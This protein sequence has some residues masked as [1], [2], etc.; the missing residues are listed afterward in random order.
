MSRALRCATGAVILVCSCG[1]PEEPDGIETIHAAVVGTEVRLQADGTRALSEP[2]ITRT[3]VAGGGVRMVSV[4]NDSNSPQSGTQMIYS[5]SRS[6]DSTSWTTSWINGLTNQGDDPSLVGRPGASPPLFAFNLLGGAANGFRLWWT[7]DPCPPTG[8]TTWFSRDLT[9]RPGAVD[10]PLILRSQDTLLWAT[11]NEPAPPD[12]LDKIFVAHF[13]TSGF[14]TTPVANACSA[15]MNHRIKYANAVGLNN[16]DHD[17]LA[18]F[19]DQTDHAVKTQIFRN[20]TG[21]WDCSS[22]KTVGSFQLPTNRCPG[23][24][25]EPT[26]HNLDSGC[27]RGTF[28]PSIALYRDVNGN[29]SIVVSYTTQAVDASCPTMQEIRWYRMFN[30][31]PTNSWTWE[32]RTGCNM[33]LQPRTVVANGIFHTN[34]IWRANSQGQIAQVDWKSTDKGVTWSGAFLT[35]ARATHGPIVP[36]SCYWGD[37]QGAVGVPSSS[38]VWFNYTVWDDAPGVNVWDIHGIS[39]D[40]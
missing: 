26:Y 39:N 38:R 17:L 29:D 24:C 7:D 12:N 9:P 25:G 22:I 11:W 27:L 21:S 16:F 2:D 35:G 5:C 19:L 18:V 13:D 40:L 1:A 14:T 30:Y 32:A 34:S 6:E 33:G 8:G 20:A 10:Y 28:N 4:G 36:E 23:V 31:T 3:T 15:F 37:Y